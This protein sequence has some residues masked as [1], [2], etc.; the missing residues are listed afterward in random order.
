MN[1]ANPLIA[2]QDCDALHRERELAP[3]ETARCDRCDAVLYKAKPNGMSQALALTVSAAVCF[4]VANVY[5]VLGFA[6]EGR[7]QLS[8]LL[9]G[10]IELYRSGMWGLSVL[11][12]IASIGVPAVRILGLLYVLVPLQG[13]YPPPHAAIIF[14]H[15]QNL[16]PWAMIEVYMLGLLVAIVK[17]AQLA[18]IVWGP[19]L[20]AFV[21]LMFAIAAADA[22]L[23]PRDIWKRVRTEVPA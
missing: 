22:A 1:N 8:T 9:T 19:A 16:K 11:V 14:R 21:A 6:L 23:E 15:L 12:F 10:V 17:L 20:Y 5:P 3:G 4:V 2:C 13:G 18:T 7:V